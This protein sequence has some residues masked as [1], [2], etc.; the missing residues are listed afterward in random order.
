MNDAIGPDN[1]FAPK[2]NRPNRWC[3]HDT[4]MAK[5]LWLVI[6]ALRLSRCPGPG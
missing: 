5:P 4:A 6:G 2:S 1:Q 3:A